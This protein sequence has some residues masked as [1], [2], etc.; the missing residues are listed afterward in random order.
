MSVVKIFILPIALTLSIMHFPI[1]CDASCGG[2]TSRPA[3]FS[4]TPASFH[5]GALLRRPSIYEYTHRALNTERDF[6]YWL[7]Q[8]K[9]MGVA[10]IVGSLALLG[11]VGAVIY[12]QSKDPSNRYPSSTIGPLSLYIGTPAIVGLAVG[13][14]FLFSDKSKQGVDNP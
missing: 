11:L 2:D 3:F 6:S 13:M 1:H 7:G 8:K 14:S 9:V 12:Q 5:Q 10:L 4:Y